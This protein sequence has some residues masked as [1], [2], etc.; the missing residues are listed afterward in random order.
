MEAL[1]HWEGG[2]PLAAAAAGRGNGAPQSVL[3]LLLQP[4]PSAPPLPHSNRHQ[5]PFHF[6]DS[7]IPC[8]MATFRGARGVMDRVHKRCN[9]LCL[10]RY[11]HIWG[12]IYQLP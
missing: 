1:T 12:T 2:D 4:A 10:T 8:H 7:T 9:L 3:D 6:L 5:N 11:N